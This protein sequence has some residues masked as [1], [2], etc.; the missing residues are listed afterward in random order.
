MHRA[1]T[2][3]QGHAL[4]TNKQVVIVVVPRVSKG[5]GLGADVR[6]GG[7]PAVVV[8]EWAAGWERACSVC[9]RAG[10]HGRA[11]GSR[12]GQGGGTVKTLAVGLQSRAGAEWEQTGSRPGAE[13]EQSGSRVE[14]SRARDGAARHRWLPDLG[15]SS[16]CL[17]LVALRIVSREVLRQRTP[18][19]C[20][21]AATSYQI[22]S[23]QIGPDLT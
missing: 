23:D 22:R 2:D 20:A 18:G 21:Q 11:R 16:R 4:D 14:R 19:Q 10:M 6:G 17:V 15:H 1:L 7:R 13:R 5:G 3:A 12:E 9:V 8:P